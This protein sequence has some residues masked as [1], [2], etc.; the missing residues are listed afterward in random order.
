MKTLKI[1]LIAAITIAAAQ[2]VFAQHKK[3]DS[4]NN[5]NTIYRCTMHS[6]IVSNQPDYCPVCG[7]ALN[8]SPKEKLKWSQLE[9]YTCPMHPDIRS[10][11]P[12]KCQI[13]NSNLT[14]VTEKTEQALYSCPMHPNIKSN[15]PGKCSICGMNLTKKTK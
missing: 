11:K 14:P 1:L 2:Q 8:L 13:C 5:S 10:D 7:A 15:K 6:N 3:F 9:L 12:G 4:T